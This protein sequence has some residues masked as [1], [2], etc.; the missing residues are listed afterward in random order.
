MSGGP[1]QITVIGIPTYKIGLEPASGGAY[2]RH[3]LSL[4]YICLQ[5]TQRR[6]CKAI[7]REVSNLSPHSALR[8]FPADVCHASVVFGHGKDYY[9]TEVIESS[10][11]EWNQEASM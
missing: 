1:A 4:V 2:C 9:T 5:F 11:P 8:V 7:R 6:I 10:T 3:R